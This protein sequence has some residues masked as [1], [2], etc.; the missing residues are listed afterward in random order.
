M[1]SDDEIL[2]DFLGRPFQIGRFV[3]YAGYS[4]AAA[5]M[6]IGMIRGTSRN[7]N[8]RV[9]LFDSEGRKT[10]TAYAERVVMIEDDVVPQ[11]IRE[12][13]LCFRR[14]LAMGMTL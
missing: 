4:G 13:L 12:R 14:G 6:R 11:E 2:Q 7:G 9:K 10:G 8:F 1:M 5:E 3:I